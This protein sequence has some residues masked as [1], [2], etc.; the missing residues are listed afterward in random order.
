MIPMEDAQADSAKTSIRCPRCNSPLAKS[1]LTGAHPITCARCKA[2]VAIVQDGPQVV[3]SSNEYAVHAGVRQPASDTTWIAAV[4]PTCGSRLYGTAEQVGVTLK[5]P[6]CHGSVV[7]SPSASPEVVDHV[8]QRAAALGEYAVRAARSPVPEAPVAELDAAWVEVKCSH[9]GTRL[10]PSRSLVGRKIACPD[11]NTRLVVPPAPER[12]VQRTLLVA[13]EGE[14]MTLGPAAERPVAHVLEYAKAAAERPIEQPPRPSTLPPL[15]RSTL[16][17]PWYAEVVGRWAAMA[18]AW[19]L[20]GEMLTYTLAFGGFF[21]GYVPFT[22]VYAFLVGMGAAGIA[23]LALPYCAATLVAVIDETA[24]GND[25]IAEWPTVEWHESFETF[26][27]VA[28]VTLLAASAGYGVSRL[29]GPSWIMPGVVFT[30]HPFLL[31]SAIDSCS[32][33]SPFSETVTGSLRRSPAAWLIFYVQFGI[34]GGGLLAT[35]A[36]V[37]WSPT[38]SWLVVAPAWSAWTLFYGRLL[39]RLGWKIM[40]AGRRKAS[41]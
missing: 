24:H 8:S 29:A 40:N 12:P 30:L 10:H 9:C 19:F 2:Q 18:V 39:G 28:F 11:C 34:L 13:E 7:L 22:A 16:P 4:C 23:I 27:S 14:A 1:A 21:V 5:C 31:L 37:A 6:D 3:P 36:L 15:I 17:F 38:V 25:R 20:L 35:L 32:I 26:L 41:R 33:F